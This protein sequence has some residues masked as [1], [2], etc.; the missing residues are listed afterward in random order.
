MGLQFLNSKWI[1]ILL[2]IIHFKHIW[3]IYYLYTLI[4]SVITTR[5]ELKLSYLNKKRELLQ[6]EF[7]L[8]NFLCHSFNNNGLNPRTLLCKK[9]KS[10]YLMSSLEKYLQLY[11]FQV[12][13]KVSMSD[14]LALI[15]ADTHWLDFISIQG[16]HIS[17]WKNTDFFVV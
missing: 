9:K 5:S 16:R 10:N 1:S 8:Q 7:S 13:R 2:S 14:I 17:V 11:N 4:L 15:L 12:E 6:A 3:S